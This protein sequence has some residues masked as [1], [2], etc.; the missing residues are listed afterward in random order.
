[1]FGALTDWKIQ[2]QFKMTYN[3]SKNA[4]TADILLK[5]GY[6]NYYYVTYN[7]DSNKVD[8]IRFQGDHFETENDYLIV[9]YLKSRFY[10]THEIVGYAI[11]NSRKN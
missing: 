4:Y 9:I 8:C 7:A 6:Y 3:A 1:L 11:L 5:Q 2:D 10:E